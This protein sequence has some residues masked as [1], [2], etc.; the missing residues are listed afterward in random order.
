M[1]G[2][3]YRDGKG[4]KGMDRHWWEWI[5]IILGCRRC[6]EG[7]RRCMENGWRVMGN[8]WECM[9]MDWGCIGW[10]WGGIKDMRG[11]IGIDRAWVGMN[12]TRV[13]GLVDGCWYI[14]SKGMIWTHSEWLR[15][16]IGKK[17]C[18]YS[19]WSNHKLPIEWAW[20][21]RNE[22]LWFFNV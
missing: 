14:R 8:R 12:G 16:I 6:I 1:Y 7:V 21:L 4:W 9:E 5:G 13:G 2:F 10:E 19:S 15:L 18:V 3:R 17:K 22:N 20:V 11:R